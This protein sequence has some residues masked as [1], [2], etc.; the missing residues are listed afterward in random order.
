MP[1][2]AARRPARRASV[3]H[4]KRSTLRG[5]DPFEHV[6]KSAGEVHDWLHRTR[7]V[8]LMNSELRAMCSPGSLDFNLPDGTPAGIGLAVARDMAQKAMNRARMRSLGRSAAESS[9]RLAGVC[10]FIEALRAFPAVWPKPEAETAA[11]AYLREAPPVRLARSK[12]RVRWSKLLRKRAKG[13]KLTAA[14]QKFMNSCEAEL[15]SLRRKVDEGLRATIEAHSTRAIQLPHAVEIMALAWAEGLAD[16]PSESE[17]RRLDRALVAHRR[18]PWPK[19]YGRPS[20][21][22]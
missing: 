18:R 8:P 9:V 16:R 12:D 7:G 10:F 2:K 14:Q 6:P 22:P 1:R 15:M 19:G 3:D 5:E 4:R 11:A 20:G 21:A 17:R 13:C